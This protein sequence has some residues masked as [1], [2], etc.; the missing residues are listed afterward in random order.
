MPPPGQKKRKRRQEL[1]RQL[2]CAQQALHAHARR[3]PARSPW[4]GLHQVN[5]WAEQLRLAWQR[6]RAADSLHVHHKLLHADATRIGRTPQR[7]QQGQQAGQ[8]R[9]QQSAEQVQR[10]ARHFDAAA[11]QHLATARQLAQGEAAAA[12]VDGDL[13]WQALQEAADSVTQ[14]AA[15]EWLEQSY[16]DKLTHLETALNVLPVLPAATT[17]HDSLLR[18]AVRAALDGAFGI[19]HQNVEVGD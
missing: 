18:H 12:A 8:Q 17:D 16:V 4:G 13:L 7:Q 10:T 1:W 14:T 3:R 15:S 9:Q 2:E 11:A 6:L 19:A 5:A